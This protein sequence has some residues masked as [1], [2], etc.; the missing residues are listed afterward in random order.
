MYALIHF[1]IIKKT[2]KSICVGKIEKKRPSGR[3]PRE[4]NIDTAVQETQ[5]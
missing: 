3:G 5:K 4:I 2:S 1:R